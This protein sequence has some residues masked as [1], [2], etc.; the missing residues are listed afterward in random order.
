MYGLDVQWFHDCEGPP[1]TKV[2]RC[3]PSRYIEKTY[4]LLFMYVFAI[5]S[6]VLSL[7]EILSLVYNYVKKRNR[8]GGDDENGMTDMPLQRV[9]DQKFVVFYLHFYSFIR[10][11]CTNTLNFNDYFIGFLR[12]LIQYLITI[13]QQYKKKLYFYINKKRYS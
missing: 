11:I 8:K 7:F 5:I 2:I 4:L 13:I 3:Y 10:K 9:V 1:C 6:C 12:A